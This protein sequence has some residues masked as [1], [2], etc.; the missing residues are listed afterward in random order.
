MDKH[1]FVWKNALKE[2]TLRQFKNQWA[3][4]DIQ[5]GTVVQE[6]WRENGILHINV[7]ELLAATETVKCLAKNS[8]HVKLSVENSVAFAHLKKVGENSP[9]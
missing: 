8:E 3:G 7:K 9:T 6:F 5:N 4:L 2:T 1:N